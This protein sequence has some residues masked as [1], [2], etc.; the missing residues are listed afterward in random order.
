MDSGL[1]TRSAHD[2]DVAVK[3]AKH[4]CWRRS[5]LGVGVCNLLP[6]AHHI[7]DLPAQA[8]DAGLLRLLCAGGGGGK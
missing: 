6:T 1:S 4:Y 5:G 8:G 7:N 3:K 2:V